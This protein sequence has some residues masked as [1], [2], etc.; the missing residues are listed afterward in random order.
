MHWEKDAQKGKLLIDAR[1]LHERGQEDAASELYAVIAPL[2]EELMQH[3]QSV[4]VWP[5]FFSHAFSAIHCWAKAGNFYRARQ[6]CTAILIHPETT[7]AL[8]EKAEL[9][10]S[11]LRE[12]QQAYWRSSQQKIAA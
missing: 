6:L 10:L 5:V 1:I 11:A 2:E 3:C 12:G 4:A 9:I 7:P 8:R